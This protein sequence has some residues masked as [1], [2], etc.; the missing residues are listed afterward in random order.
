MKL[1]TDA[2]A[3]LVFYIYFSVGK[4][5]CSCQNN[6]RKLNSNVGTLDKNMETFVG[7]SFLND[8]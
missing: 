8:G 6:S 5:Y 3:T 1:T 2:I 7:V 4:K